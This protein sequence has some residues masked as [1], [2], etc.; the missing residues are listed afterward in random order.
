MSILVF[1]EEPETLLVESTQAELLVFDD[2]TTL[3][4]VPG[5]TDTD[6]LLFDVEAPIIE[7]ATADPDFLVIDGQ[8]TT[9]T[10]NLNGLEDFLVF[11]APPGP[12]GVAP[13]TY[14]HRQDTP[15][16]EWHVPHMM[17]R[18]PVATLFLDEDPS[19]PVWTDLTYS[20]DNN[21]LVTWPSPVT[22]WV[23]L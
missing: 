2:E 7:E 11:S 1:D 17:N 10:E 23:Y 13:G 21:L 9:Y 3:Q 6:F 8:P 20:D 18:K 19:E 14:V 22:G 16:A 12:P 4:E 15:S 5:G